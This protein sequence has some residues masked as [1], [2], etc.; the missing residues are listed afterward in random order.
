MQP[1]N[2]RKSPKVIP[3]A[4]Y[5]AYADHS[6]VVSS[7]EKLG[8]LKTIERQDKFDVLNKVKH[9]RPKNVKKTYC[10]ENKYYLD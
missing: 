9:H 10:F 1:I 3:L 6:G 7:T 4:N 2:F 8:V 5:Q